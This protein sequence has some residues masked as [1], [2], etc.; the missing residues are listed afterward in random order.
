MSRKVWK[1]K[2]MDKAY[3]GVPKVGTP[4]TEC[5]EVDGAPAQ[6][7]D[8]QASDPLAKAAEVAKSINRDGEPFEPAANRGDLPKNLKT[9]P[10][11][12]ALASAALAAHALV[13]KAGKPVGT[14]SHRKDGDY[15]KAG[16]GDWRRKPGNDGG[17]AGYADS[18]EMSAREGAYGEARRNG[19]SHE[20][21]QAAADA[22]VSQPPTYRKAGWSELKQ[23]S[24][25]NEGVAYAVHDVVNN[26]MSLE[27]A[28]DNQNMYGDRPD[29]VRA[30]EKVKAVLSQLEEPEAPA[31]DPRERLSAL[32]GANA[33]EVLSFFEAN[34]D[35]SDYDGPVPE[36]D[37]EDGNSYNARASDGSLYWNDNYDSWDP[38]NDE[39]EDE[40]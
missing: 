13:L 30:Q 24:G 28:L 17:K 36:G 12:K 1:S 3:L 18:Q 15:V 25:G 33:D 23:L 2:D 10:V 37:D 35:L 19:A 9:L 31:Q 40:D 20:E 32:E 4:P 16:E 26:G 21:G 6:D 5:D 8:G 39:E 22:A 27:E 34:P 29:I 38:E 14:V 11:E 7:A